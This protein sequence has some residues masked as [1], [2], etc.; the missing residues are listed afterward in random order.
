MARRKIPSEK[1]NYKLHKRRLKKYT[2]AVN[3]V[4]DELSRSLCAKV[5]YNGD[6]ADR[7]AVLK[8]VSQLIKGNKKDFARD[9]VSALNRTIKLASSMEWDISES[10]VDDLVNA[11]TENKT[12]EPP[13]WIANSLKHNEDARD[14]FL[15]RRDAN[16]NVVSKLQKQAEHYSTLIGESIAS[17]IMKGT[18]AVS[19]ASQVQSYL[20]DVDKLNG[21]YKEYVGDEGRAIN[22]KYTAMRLART[23]INSAYKLAEQERYQ[24]L[25]FVVGYEVHRSGD[26][27]EQI[28]GDSSRK[29]KCDLC[30]SLKGKYPKDFVFTNWHPNCYSDDT[31]VLTNRGWKLFADVL[32]DDLIYSLNPES[33]SPEYTSFVAR[34]KY[35]I[36]DEMIRFFN[37]STDMLVTKDHRMVYLDKVEKKISFCPA[38]DFS[39]SKGY[40]YKSSKYDACDIPFI[41][42]GNKQY[43][44][45]LFCE[46]MGYWLSDGST[47][48]KSQIL[49]SQKTT[50]KAHP[51][52]LRCL[53]RL[54][55][56]VHIETDHLSVYDSELCSYLKQF[57]TCEYKY[58]PNEIKNASKRQI[59]IFL[60]AFIK[61]DGSLRKA[62]KFV[63]NR[64]GVCNNAHDERLYFTTSKMLCA[65]LC[66]LIIKI[67]HRPSIKEQLPK[68]S[69]KRDG[70]I[71]RSKFIVYKI[72]EC[73]SVSASE[74]KKEYVDYEGY[75]YDLT[76][77]KN[78]IMLVCRNGKVSWGSNCL[79]YITPILN[80]SD[81]FWSWDGRGVPP[82][83]VNEVTEPPQ[84]F[85][86]YVANME[87]SI[88][89]KSTPYFIK[90]NI[91]YVASLA[92]DENKSSV[93]DL[94]LLLGKK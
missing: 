47:I 59:Q 67:G 41:S 20:N 91:A 74:F 18:S 31:F 54:F 27:D 62:K 73:F 3:S 19:L 86:D 32:D 63:G 24:N 44:F 5:D 84:G 38:N 25:D 75:V 65:D 66:D 21:D 53:Q 4:I 92:T 30:E 78:H 10:N 2:S 16:G 71:I 55:P 52:I 45:D 60:D 93:S 76:L 51:Y 6:I 61:C 15:R 90:D 79:C 48:R 68:V 43:N 81:E 28:Y 89:P 94:A 8:Y 82:K 29:H 37:L 57:R 22:V 12:I 58:V 72:N 9:Y 13:K 64:G 56:C 36:K 11:I 85:K 77:A 83:S 26:L 14:A 34:Q 7:D 17:A 88:K 50:E 80:T 70:T 1:K 40:I 42:I 46:F 69:T 23:E 33:M 39:K 49:I 87:N 35:H